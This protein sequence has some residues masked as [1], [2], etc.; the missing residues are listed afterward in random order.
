MISSTRCAAARRMRPARANMHMTRRCNGSAEFQR[1]Q[2]RGRTGCRKCQH[3]ARGA[4][5]EVAAHHASQLIKVV[6]LT[7]GPGETFNYRKFAAPTM[8]PNRI[9]ACDPGRLRTGQGAGILKINSFAHR[10]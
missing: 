10:L 2:L 6:T 1:R 7:V 9:R 3:E 4:H 8:A 5:D